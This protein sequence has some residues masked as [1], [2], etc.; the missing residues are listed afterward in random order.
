MNLMPV[1]KLAGKYTVPDFWVYVLVLLIFKK[2][3]S[4]SMWTF[5][6]NWLLF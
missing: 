5:K 1:Q 2:I 3:V 4:V 6:V